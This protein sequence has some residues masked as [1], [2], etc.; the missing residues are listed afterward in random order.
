M[1]D[2]RPQATA[3]ATDGRTDTFADSRPRPASDNGSSAGSAASGASV[4]SNGRASSAAVGQAA[5]TLRVIADNVARAVK[6]KP[7]Q[8]DTAVLCLA[9][10]GH[11]LVEDVPGVG[12]T[13]LA[14]ALAASVSGI[15]NR[16]QFT[17]DL[18]PSDLTGVTIVDP[19]TSKFL[20][21]PGPLFG[22]VV[23]CDE[24][25]RASPKVQSALLE[26]ME[27]RQISVDRETH[28]L[29]RPFMVIATQNPIE[30][31]GTYPLPESQLD[32]FLAR[33]SI[34]YPSRDA[35][36]SVLHEHGRVNPVDALEPVT[37]V[38]TVTRVTRLVPRIHVAP[39]L[40]GYVVDVLAHTREHGD[41]RLGGSPRAG[42]AWVR[43][44]R[45]RALASGCEY[46]TPDDLQAVAATVLCH[47]LLPRGRGID[48]GAV[49][50]EVLASV[51]VP[52]SR[53]S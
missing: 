42:L 3:T 40:F 12:K 46:I 49:L 39:V 53:R 5:E 51:P 33:I 29:P 16:V 23:L 18:L 34:G 32:R 8:I 15:T 11:L 17:P 21:R 9:A 30:Q 47:R 45:A 28:A 38:A 6:G 10:E 7:H 44:A 48:V 4:E 2:D 27:E 31:E 35:E 25:N 20:F 24:I 36:M 50:N 37:D 14:K 52:G 41:L 19:S 26:A 43:M 13:L 1:T 22:N